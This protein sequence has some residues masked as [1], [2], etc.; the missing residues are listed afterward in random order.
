MGD[1]NETADLSK[2]EGLRTTTTWGEPNRNQL[3]QDG[4]PLNAGGESVEE[5]SK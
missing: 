3:D 5:K 2:G 1:I 4:K